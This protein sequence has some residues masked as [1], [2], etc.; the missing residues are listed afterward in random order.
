M[1]TDTKLEAQVVVQ[2][3]FLQAMAWQPALGKKV[4]DIFEEKFQQHYQTV[5][6]GSKEDPLLGELQQAYSAFCRSI[7]PGI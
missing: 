6:A 1:T 2:G 4:R 5:Y 7:P 3:L